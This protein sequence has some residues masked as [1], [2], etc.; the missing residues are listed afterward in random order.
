[1]YALNL[2]SLI[3]L[4]ILLILFFGVLF[5]Y[6]L[7]YARLEE[8]SKLE[9]EKE[10]KLEEE[11]LEPEEELELEEEL[12]PEP[13]EDTKLSKLQRDYYYL[14]T[15]L[16]IVFFNLSTQL[17]LS[18]ERVEDN[19]LKHNLSNYGSILELTF[20]VLN[21]T[22]TPNEESYECIKQLPE[23]LSYRNGLSNLT[24]A[25]HEI[26][27]LMQESEIVV[28]QIPE[29]LNLIYEIIKLEKEVS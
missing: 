19:E 2:Q 25:P 17:Q 28:M 14:H 10:K 18:R 26:Q 5:I 27:K 1:M 29:L 20:A 7:L 9:T 22:N 13:E 3:Y 15:E 8:F 21:E 16:K 12:E 11:E 4:F 23:Y 6:L 24:H